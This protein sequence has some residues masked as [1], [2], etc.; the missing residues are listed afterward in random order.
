VSETTSQPQYEAQFFTSVRGWGI[1]RGENGVIGGVVEGV[2]ERIGLARV[3]ARLLAV[4]LALITS[5]LFITAYAAAWALLP[6]S[7]GRI[8]VQDFGRG[9]PNVPSLIGIAI[10]GLIG[11]NGLAWTGPLGWGPI[12]VVLATFVGLI[13]V[14][15]IIALI[16]WSVTRDE[17]GQSRLVVEFRNPEGTKAWTE[18]KG[19]DAGKKAREAAHALRDEAKASGKIIANEGRATARRVKASAAEIRD[20]VTVKSR[21]KPSTPRVPPVPPAPPTP[22]AH[23]IPP[24]PRVPGPGKAIR[25]LALA[26]M[27]LTGA[28]VWWLDRENILT[29]NPVEAWLAAMIIV[30]GVAIILAGAA[31]RRI[32]GFGFWAFVLII[33]WS[34]RIVVG[35]HVEEFFDSHDFFF[36]VHDSPHVVSVEDGILDCRS[37]DDSL[38]DRA[39][40]RI[41][42]I[43]KA[44]YAVTVTEPDTTIVVPD[45]ASITVRADHGPLSAT[46]SWERLAGG[47]DRTQFATCV[48]DGASSRFRTWG[49]RSTEIDITVTVPNANIIIEER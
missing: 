48:I 21:T 16:A 39:T 23:P 47:D 4:F 19:R 45:R 11:L 22:P 25:L 2:G 9:T 46:V 24:R 13:V 27:F 35:P 37:F 40:T 32:G 44:D 38:A 15:G 29:V 26:G 33:G 8:I 1:T 14:A 6:D 36:D 12:G 20:A 42:V 5:G 17:H 41:Y 30:V 31:G 49:S 10:L 34:I 28:V 3:P 43:D 18:Q 7:K